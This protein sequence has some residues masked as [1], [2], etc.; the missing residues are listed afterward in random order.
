MLH[1]LWLLATGAEIDDDQY[2][3]KWRLRGRYDL[4]STEG[5]LLAVLA[6]LPFW[7]L[8]AALVWWFS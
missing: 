3:A 4:A 2:Q 7:G 6:S 5:V 1:D 8:L